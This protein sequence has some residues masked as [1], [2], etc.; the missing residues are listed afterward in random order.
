MSGIVAQMQSQLAQRLA[1][2]VEKAI[3]DGEIPPLTVP[4]FIVE[5]PREKGHG[6]FA[7]NLALMLAKPAKN[8]PRKLAEIIVNK[9]ELAGTSVQKVEIAGPGFIN[10]HLDPYWMH[11]VLLQ[12][13]EQGEHYGRVDLGEGTK[14]QVEFVSANPTGLLHMGNARGAALGDS[15]ASILEFAG[16][17]VQ[18]EYYI[19]DAGNQIEN[20]GRS[21][22]A[23]YLQQLGQDV[24]LPEE[25]YHGED[26]IDTV[27]NFIQQYQDKYL[28]VDGA[29]RR[30]KLVQFALK[31][32]LTAIK[33]TLL[34]FGVIYDVWFSE[35]SLHQ[36][37]AIEE[38]IKELQ[39][40]GYIYE[41]ENAL[42]FKA[43]AFGDEKDE[44][45]VRSN[46]IPTYFAA[47]I[48]YHKNKFQRGFQRVINIWGADHHGHVNRM[49]GSMEALGYNRDSLE[50]I[51]MQLVRLLRGGEVVR[52]SKR[53]GRFVTLSELIAEVGKDAARYFF[54]MR[55]PDS[56]LEFDLDL[57]KSQ[58]NDN[59]VFYIQY[60]H[61]R[62]CSIFRQLAERGGE[63]PTAKEVDLKVLQNEQEINL[64]RK[65]AH[66]PVEISMAA[67]TMAPH[68]IAKYLHELAGLF[69]SFYNSSRVIVDDPRLSAARL[70][71]V[72]ATGIVLRNGLRLIGVSAPEK[73]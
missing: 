44:V 71:L 28:N 29:T 63:K 18:R 46:G 33:N 49:K 55:S 43:T 53:T 3:Q 27:K 2:A 68:R 1:Q 50:I 6:D 4:E 62:I 67:Q 52:M 5:V 66:F 23:R 48:A 72:N 30:E 51:L 73:M 13:E 56:H 47:D 60:A 59:P 69:H 12:V 22:E 19:N 64:I 34:D 17:D 21:L 32:K 70:V 11:R 25:G 10:F 38:T 61:A 40:K 39:Q 20:F 37:G 16:Y 31:E 8:A 41:H 24:P 45:V 54:I 15:L 14:V 26:L 65:L 9:L 36:S 42:W 35:Q 7:T 58:T 57:A